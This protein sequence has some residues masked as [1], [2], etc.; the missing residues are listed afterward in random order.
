MPITR[1]P[2]DL[3]GLIEHTDTINKIDRQFQIFDDNLFNVQYTNQTA[4]MF[5]VNETDTTLLPATDRG[6]KGSTYGKDDVV[7]T[8][9]L[10]LAYFKHSDYITS[11]DLQGVRQVGT[12]DGITTL[13]IARAKKLVNMRRKLDQNLEYLKLQAVKG[14]FKSADGSFVVDAFQEFGVTQDVVDF[15]LGTNTTDV[16]GKIRALRR[17][18]KDNLQNGGFVSGI[19]IYVAPDF[20]DALITHETVKEAYKYYQGVT[21]QAGNAQPLRDNLNDVFAFGGVRFISL[22]GSFSLP[23][24]GSEDLIEAGVGHVVPQ[25]PDLFRG[26]Y[27]P[28]NKLELATSVGSESYAWEYR[29]TKGEYHELQVESSPLF[30]CSRPKAL[31]KVTA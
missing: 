25:T 9:A 31:I 28:S 29:D 23:N 11:G 17:M 30:F 1:D 24:G 16:L 7:S 3:Y 19:D 20:Y 4:V 15:Q 21:N 2:Q 26:Y 8:R 5:D 27:G 14:I 10:P 13:D 22:D 18:L 12:P 6:A